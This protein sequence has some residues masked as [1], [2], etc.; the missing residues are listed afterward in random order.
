MSS[1]G[2]RTARFAGLVLSVAHGTLARAEFGCRAADS[3]GPL[4]QV[5]VAV[6]EF[7]LLLRGKGHECGDEHQ[8]LSPRAHQL[9]ELEDLFDGRAGRSAAFSLPPTMAISGLRPCSSATLPPV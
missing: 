3:D 2:M 7:G 9:G 1:D 5:D 4:L 8:Q 6:P